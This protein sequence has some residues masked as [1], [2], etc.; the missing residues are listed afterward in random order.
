MKESIRGIESSGWN[1]MVYARK[2]VRSS[3][4]K[5]GSSM[6]KKTIMIAGSPINVIITII[7][8]ISSVKCLIKYPNLNFG[9]ITD[10]IYLPPQASS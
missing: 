9:A 5:T 4:S 2:G 6:K 8:K 3:P 10:I 7:Q 1:N